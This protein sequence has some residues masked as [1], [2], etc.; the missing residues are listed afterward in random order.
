MVTAPFQTNIIEN[1]VVSS[2]H[3]TSKLRCLIKDAYEVLGK[4]LL[5]PGFEYILWY[6]AP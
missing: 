1:T 5:T 2:Q 4:L 6:L 3:P